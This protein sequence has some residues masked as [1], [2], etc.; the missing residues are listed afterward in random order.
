MALAVAPNVDDFRGQYRDAVRL[1]L[2][3]EYRF[4]KRGIA[5]RAG[6]YRDPVRYIGGGKVPDIQIETDP[7]AWTLGFG[8][9]LEDAVVL[10]VAAVLGGYKLKEGNRADRVRTVRILASARFYFDV[11]PLEEP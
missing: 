3:G 9:D 4:L 11:M 1:H 2:G 10:D 6:Y 8:A 7:D 5:L